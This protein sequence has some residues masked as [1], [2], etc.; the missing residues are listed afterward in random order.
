VKLLRVI[1]LG[2]LVSSI[3][4]T[5]AMAYYG[6]GLK[7]YNKFVREETHLNPQ[8]LVNELNVTKPEE[9]RALLSNHAEGIIKF[10]K[11]HGYDKSAEGFEKMAHS[12]DGDKKLKNVG[13]FFIGLM[14]G[15][16]LPECS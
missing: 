14:N 13:D 9:I 4:L 6:L 15:K 12:K 10:L 5:S 2:L 7:Y 16:V 8:V 1:M 11:L 3:S